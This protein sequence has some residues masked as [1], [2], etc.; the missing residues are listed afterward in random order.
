M[1]GIGQW[2]IWKEGHGLVRPAKKSNSPKETFSSLR[3]HGPMHKI[4]DAVASN[5]QGAM[6]Q[7]PSPP[8]PTKQT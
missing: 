3:G 5:G 1:G 4:H 7:Y 8:P 2:R 6:P